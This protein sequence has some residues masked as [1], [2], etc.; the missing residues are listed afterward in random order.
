MY[1]AKILALEDNLACHIAASVFTYAFIGD[2]DFDRKSSKAT[3]HAH[4]TRPMIQRKF[5]MVNKLLFVIGNTD[6]GI[7]KTR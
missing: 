1:A 6:S 7:N 3:W 5:L 2:V 4:K